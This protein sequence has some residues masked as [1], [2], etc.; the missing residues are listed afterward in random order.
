MTKKNI[1]IVTAAII[2]KG[3]S[4]LLTK[5]LAES[6]HA[7]KWEFPGG[8]LE[9][10]ESPAECLQREL[11]EELDLKIDVGAIYD[12][13]HHRYDFGPIL[14]LTYECTALSKPI[15]NLQVTEHR[16]VPLHQLD[17]YDMLPADIPLI[18]KLMAETIR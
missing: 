18:K 12:V 11:R 15:R 14:L 3:H 5:R 17:Q 6:R 16:F 13:I 9:A 10:G 1:L 7:G 2:R 8:K 4:V